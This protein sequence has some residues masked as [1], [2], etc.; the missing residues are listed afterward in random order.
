VLQV[1]AALLAVATSLHV[2]T[3]DLAAAVVMAL[4]MG[5]QNGAFGEETGISAPTYVTGT[6]VKVG[7]QLT[8]VLFGG[9]P[10]ALRHHASLWLGLI[11]GAVAGTWI[12]TRLGLHGLWI[13]AGAAL[14]LSGAAARLAP[15]KG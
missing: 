6:L 1:V 11:C 5:V 12:F 8:A 9:P 2:F 10:D 15:A 4:A 13:A 14:L 3:L 7:Q